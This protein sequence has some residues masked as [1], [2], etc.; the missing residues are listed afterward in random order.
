MRTILF[1]REKVD[2]YFK[3]VKKF[4]SSQMNNLSAY[5]HEHPFDLICRFS[6]FGSLVNNSYLCNVTKSLKTIIVTNFLNIY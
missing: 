4:I 1:Y 6:G 5:P 2:V 3:P